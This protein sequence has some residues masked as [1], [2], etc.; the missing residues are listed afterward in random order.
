M[1]ILDAIF[2]DFNMFSTYIL[3]IA[4]IPS[5]FI[6]VGYLVYIVIKVKLIIFIINCIFRFFN[7]LRGVL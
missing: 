6:F 1:S 3:Q 5:E 2:A 7:I 4:E